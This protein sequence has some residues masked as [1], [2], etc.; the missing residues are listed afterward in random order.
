MDKQ[1]IQNLIKELIEKTTVG[2]REIVMVE[3][4][5][6]NTWFWV[7]VNEPRFFI[8]REGEA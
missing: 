8:D 5:P 1:A 7:E 2:V 6:A 3:E 4:T